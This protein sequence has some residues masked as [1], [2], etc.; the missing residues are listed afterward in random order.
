MDE[1][2]PEEQENTTEDKDDGS[3]PKTT[4]IVDRAYAE[5]KRMEENFKKR[6]ELLAREEDFWAKK[7]L[8]G[9]ADAGEPQKEKEE[10][11]EEY[12]KRVMEG[13]I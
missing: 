11:P 1:K 9:N 2:K 7:Q 3:K 5:N 10:T 4:G 13:R 8:A 12:K 6:E